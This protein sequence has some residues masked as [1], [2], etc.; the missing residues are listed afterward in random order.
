VW[1]ENG[2]IFFKTSAL[3]DIQKWIQFLAISIVVVF[4]FTFL[5]RLGIKIGIGISIGIGILVYM[6]DITLE[7]GKNTM[8][9]YY[10]L[11]GFISWKRE[12]PVTEI[13]NVDHSWLGYCSI[14]TL[15]RSYRISHISGRESREKL[16]GFIKKQLQEYSG[17]RPKKRYEL[18]GEWQHPSR[19]VFPPSG[20]LVLDEIGFPIPVLLIIGIFVVPA[21]VL[22]EV[23][24]M[25]MAKQFIHIPE[26][27]S[28]DILPVF[29]IL[30]IL[31]VVWIG[32]KLMKS[33]AVVTLEGSFL[34]VRRQILKWL[35]IRS[36]FPIGKEPIL[37]QIKKSETGRINTIL[38]QQG[39]NKVCVGSTLKW[40]QLH[41]VK[42]FLEKMISR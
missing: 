31:L 39:L 2:R 22:V 32:I 8:V 11:F 42:S 16:V 34:V 36:R 18:E 21:S 30:H 33:R 12:V 17:W 15:H 1:E 28:T 9:I 25:E 5:W 41:R 3:W 29:L 24:I 7:L 26:K 10:R 23:L 38:I 13:C 20:I 19:L 27:F 37:I 6:M 4:L 35:S 14:F 40:D